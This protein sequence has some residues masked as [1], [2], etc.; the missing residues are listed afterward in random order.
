MVIRNGET[1]EFYWGM[2]ALLY[3]VVIWQRVVPSRRSGSNHQDHCD[4][5]ASQAEARQ[6][7]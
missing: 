3:V 1:K 6:A 4:A 2:T 7:A 5:E